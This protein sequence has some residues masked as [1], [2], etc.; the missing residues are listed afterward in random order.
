MP[1][2]R[3]LTW[4]EGS[5]KRQGRWTKWYQGKTY[6]FSF[7]TSKSD[8]S[9]YQQALEAWK[10]KKAEIDAEKANQR[11]PHQEEYERAIEGGVWCFNGPWSTTTSDTFA[12]LGKR[13]R[14]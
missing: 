4:Q 7:G 3:E 13:S 2:E 14:N 9:G 11:K 8:S 10:K 12:S 6:Y 1:R 5:G